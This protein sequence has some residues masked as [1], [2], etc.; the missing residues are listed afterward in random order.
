MAAS[1]EWTEWHLTSFGWI[2]GSEKT[3]STSCIVEKPPEAIASY[4]YSEEF[5]SVHSKVDAKSVCLSHASPHL[6]AA[7]SEAIAKYGECPLRL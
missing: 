1:F 5:S 2:R 4:R 6:Q 3:D 7:L